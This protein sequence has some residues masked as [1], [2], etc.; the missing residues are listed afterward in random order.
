MHI[1]NKPL[2]CQSTG[3]LV[4]FVTA[5]ATYPILNSD[6]V[7]SCLMNEKAGPQEI[8]QCQT[9]HLVL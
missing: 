7:L 9:A 2:F 6:A 5:A 4:L 8:D 1:R 3:A